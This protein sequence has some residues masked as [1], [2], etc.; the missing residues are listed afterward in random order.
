MERELFEAAVVALVLVRFVDGGEHDSVRLAMRNVLC[1]A[2][3]IAQGMDGRAAC[4]A[5]RD[6]GIRAREQE[7][8][9]ACLARGQ[10]VLL[11]GEETFD[12][13]VHRL[14]R[15]R[16]RERRRFRRRIAL[17]GMNERIDGTRAEDTV[18]QALEE[19]RDKHGLVG[20]ESRIGEPHLRAELRELEDR[21][22]RDLAARAARRRH[23]NQLVRLLRGE[24]LLIKV[25]DGRELL[26][27]EELRDVENRAA[28]D[29]EDAVIHF[30]AERLDD[31]LDHEVSRLALAIGA[32]VDDGR[33][34]K[35][36]CEMALLR[37]AARK[38]E[39]A[40]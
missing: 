15:E 40:G 38:D 36:A 28:A 24:F 12:D 3:R 34:R 23:E 22:V 16:A 33:A 7:L 10:A 21:D 11:N 14:A 26:E 29:G 19:L 5:E 37:A 20:I 18:G 25:G 4:V 1:R 9:E 32:V 8:F 6:T 2:E 35:L 31:A 39:V 17:D 30:A 27:R 13:G